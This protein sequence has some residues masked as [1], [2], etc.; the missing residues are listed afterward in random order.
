M[1]SLKSVPTTGLILI[2]NTTKEPGKAIAVVGE[3]SL[4]YWSHVYNSRKYNGVVTFVEKHP[5]LPCYAEINS[6]DP[7]TLNLIF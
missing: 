3:Y 1:S 2:E 4:H 6:L 7:E 5:G